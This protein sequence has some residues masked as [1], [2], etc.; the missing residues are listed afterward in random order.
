M[1]PMQQNPQQLQQQLMQIYQKMRQNPAQIFGQMGVPQ[2]MMND[3]DQIIQ[4]LL[5]TGKVSQQ[6]INQV[7][8]M[9]NNPMIGQIQQMIMN[10][11]R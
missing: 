7:M 9:K 6:Q 3:P 4:H 1:N 11:K 2:E 8:Q 10:S 5:N